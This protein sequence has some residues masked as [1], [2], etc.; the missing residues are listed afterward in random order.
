MNSVIFAFGLVLVLEGLLPLLA[1]SIWRETFIR[2]IKFTDGQLRFVGLG[3]LLG[4][5]VIIVLSRS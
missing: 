5:L 3:S 1:P 4:G 2:M